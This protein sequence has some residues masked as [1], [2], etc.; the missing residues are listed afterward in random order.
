MFSS[1]VL[2]TL[3]TTPDTIRNNKNY[4]K[5]YVN[6]RGFKYDSNC[7]DVLTKSNP[8]NLSRFIRQVGDYNT[9]QAQNPRWRA[10]TTVK[11]R[12]YAQYCPEGWNERSGGCYAPDSY[13]G[14]CNAGRWK[15]GRACANRF[16]WWGR[17]CYNYQY[18]QQPSYFWGYDSNAKASWANQCGANWPEKSKYLPGKWIC[19]YGQSLG[20]DVSAGQVKY[21][22]TA[23]SYLEAAKKVLL[24]NFKGA[25][26]FIMVDNHVYVATDGGSS[27][28]TSKGSYEDKCTENG[29][30]KAVL[31]E[32]TTDLFSLLEKCKR[33]NNSL[34]SAND[35]VNKLSGSTFDLYQQRVNELKRSNPNWVEDNK[36]EKY[37]SATKTIEKNLNE[38]VSNLADNYNKKVNLYNLQAEII[39]RQDSI[40]EKN[41]DKLN[42]Q[43]DT[44]VQIQDQ[45]A[46]KERVA[47]LNQDM[48]K[49]QVTNKKLL[50]GFF[51]LLPFLVIPA[52]ITLTGTTS[53]LIGLGIG[54]LMILGY[55][56]YAIVIINKNKIKKYVKPTMKQLSK[57]EKAIKNYYDKEKGKLSKNLS[58]FVYGDCN[59]PPEEMN[60]EEEEG[61][62]PSMHWKG[63]YL[64]SS[65]GPYQYYDGSAPPQ[66]VMPQPE[67]SIQF[68][69]NGLE[70]KWPKE[71]SEN[72]N[73]IMKKNP[74]MYYFFAL[75]LYM[76]DKKGI[77]VDDP[78]FNNTLNVVDFETSDATPPPY[79]QYIKLPMVTNLQKNIS[80]V[81]QSYNSRRKKIGQDAGTYLVDMWNYVYGN[82]IP[83]NIYQTWLTKINNTINKKGNVAQV[84]KDYFNYLIGLPQ[85]TEKYGSVENFLNQKI[86][87]FIKVINSNVALTQPDVERL[88]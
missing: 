86:E 9:V 4:L 38:I 12:D 32:F 28:F 51:V 27:V 21:L 56:I 8:E 57:Y 15:T 37:N 66:Q 22:G 71:V 65:N 85:F 13:N 40:V 17:Y 20:N 33:V 45:I 11:Y 48:V 44:M 75:W 74:V 23:N 76:L 24:Q 3:Y 54:G 14:P 69:L 43:L 31:Y 30:K 39:N 52:I 84:Y 29:N 18:W 83:D 73:E 47:E 19:N 78:R 42:K 81:C 25:R 70:L 49:K 60:G 79:W 68:D 62:N 16:L 2:N 55:I 7:L 87:Q 50:I 34:N 46:V 26:Y 10:P 80:Y 59:C 53:P 35:T 41:Q 67:G 77:S 64:L 6:E 1:K 88:W 61:G 36:K 82:R 58:E 72:M 5:N 63:L